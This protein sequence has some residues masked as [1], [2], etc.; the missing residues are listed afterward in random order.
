MSL[1]PD[2]YAAACRAQRQDQLAWA[3]RDRS[4]RQTN[5]QPVRRI[6]RPVRSI[7][8]TVLVRFTER[9]RGAPAP[10]E[11]ETRGVPLVAR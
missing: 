10:V 6:D 7:I 4:I 5:D 2:T 8:G 1:H 9:L 3:Q 11:A